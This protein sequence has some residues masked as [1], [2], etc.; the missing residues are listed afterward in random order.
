MNRVFIPSDGPSDWKRF[1][2]D[3]DKQ[4]ATGYSAR[5]LA[6]CW[7]DADG[8]PAE[9]RDVLEQHPVLASAEPLLV[10]PEWRVDLPG[11]RRPSQNDVWV[12][13]RC[14]E[15]LVS[16]AV[17][18]KVEEP[19][20][21]PLGEWKTESSPGKVQRL[22]FLVKTLGLSDSPPDPIRY[23]L[24]HRTASAI[25]E[26]ERYGACCAVMLVHT[27]SRQDSWFDDY[28]AFLSLFGVEAGV[29]RLSSTEVGDMPLHLG[30]VHG[31]E[32]YLEA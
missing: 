5:T 12:L 4:W 8:F 1:L 19:F 20:G 31:N 7:E 30:W 29:G 22:D 25:I 6:H 24:L 17:E 15:G 2:A 23:Q 26:A 9:V 11:G 32:R 13:A 3:P 28:S 10:F 16:I 18:G 21:E 27:F 14:D